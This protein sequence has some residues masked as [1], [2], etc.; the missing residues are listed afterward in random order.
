MAAIDASETRLFS[1]PSSFAS[2]SSFAS[3]HALQPSAEPANQTDTPAVQR[4][5]DMVVMQRPSRPPGLPATLEQATLQRTS[6]ASEL[7]LARPA[8]PA[9]ESSPA[10]Q[11]SWEDATDLTQR[12]IAY[13]EPVVMRAMAPAEMATSSDVAAQ[14]AEVAVSRSGSHLDELAEQLWDR[15]H[16][17]FRSELLVERE[18]AGLLSDRR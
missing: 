18:R 16:S 14:A 7:P 4:A 5:T 3:G 10:L 13:R 6:E 8:T 15:I 2:V 1:A 12:T 17:R 11:A 9:P